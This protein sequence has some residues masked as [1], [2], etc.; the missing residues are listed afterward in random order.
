M[1]S[2]RAFVGRRR[3]SGWRDASPCS[4]FTRMSTPVAEH[5]P[6]LSGRTRFETPPHDTSTWITD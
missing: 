6:E 4:I 5:P 2:S 1:S 3:L